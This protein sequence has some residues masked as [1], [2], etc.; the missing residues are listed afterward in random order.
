MLNLKK[1][2]QKQKKQ[3]KEKGFSLIELMIV[4]AIIGIL[5]AMAIPNFLRFQQKAKQVEAKTNLGAYYAAQKSFFAE[6]VTFF[7]D[8]RDIGYAPEGDLIYRV[9]GEDS[10]TTLPPNYNY[11]SGGCTGVDPMTGACT[12]TQAPDTM[13]YCALPDGDCTEL[14]TAVDA[15]STTEA[16]AHNTFLATATANLD[17]DITLDE[18][19]IDEG[20]DLNLVTSDL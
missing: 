4:V 15:T 14:S 7:G 11:R 17:G 19:S 13:T 16:L 3:R 9:I 5:S 18:W 2:E 8:F 20:K 12:G 1:L 10:I 6:W